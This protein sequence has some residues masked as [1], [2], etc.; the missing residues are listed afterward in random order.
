M[1]D[2]L[3]EAVMGERDDAPAEAREARAAMERERFMRAP[4]VIGVVSRVREGIAIPVWEQ[5]MSAGAVVHGDAAGGARARLRRAMD[6]RM[7]RLSMRAYWKRSGSGAANA[8]PATSISAS[9][10]CPWK[11]ARAP[12]WTR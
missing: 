4:V 1:G 2:I 12:T 3:A 9:R 8:S 6:H 7:V 5:Q 11:T 10:R